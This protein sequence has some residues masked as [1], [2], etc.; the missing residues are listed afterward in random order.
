MSSYTATPPS[1]ATVDSQAPVVDDNDNM[2]KNSVFVAESPISIRQGFIRRVY[3][4]LSAQVL[5][6][7]L[8]AGGMMTSQ[9]TKSFLQSNGGFWVIIAAFIGSFICLFGA[10][11]TAR[12]Y[13]YNLMFVSGFTLCEAFTLGCVT[14]FLDNRVVLQAFMLTSVLFI[15]LT[16]F[17]CQSRY[18]FLSWYQFL[19]ITLFVMIGF[20][21]IQMFMP[22]NHTMEMVYCGA[23][24]LIFSGMVLADTQAIMRRLHPDEVILASISLYLDFLNLFFFILRLL[25]NDDQ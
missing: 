13:P 19:N 23:G 7:T 18:D 22:Y 14:C 12:R 4:L 20:G 6:T 24:V 5:L 16:L 17:A 21:F 11:Y 25:Q 8:V 3:A 2:F 10:Q 9:S 1:Y 15:G